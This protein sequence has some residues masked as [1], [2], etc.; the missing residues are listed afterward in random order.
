MQTEEQIMQI[1]S[2]LRAIYQTAR[3][4]NAENVNQGEKQVLHYL[5][6]TGGQAQPGDISRAMHISTA[7][8]AA[9]LGSLDR[10]GQIIREPLGSDR[11][12]VQVRLTE[13]GRAR[14]DAIYAHMRDQMTYILQA[15]GPEDAGELCRILHRLP[16]ILS[17]ALP[18]Q[19]QKG[20]L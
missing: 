12:C 8:V 7:R 2:D 9:I 17:K 13:A 4:H 11:R 15:L 1:L 19:E 14:L 5:R 10:K 6:Q 20:E 3:Q 18:T 16:E